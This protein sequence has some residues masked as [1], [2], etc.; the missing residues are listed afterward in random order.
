MLVAGAV[1]EEE[2][3]E[4]GGKKREGVVNERRP[5][6]PFLISTGTPL[7]RPYKRKISFQKFL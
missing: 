2:A 6:V 1:E 7:R 4:E 5:T 3:K